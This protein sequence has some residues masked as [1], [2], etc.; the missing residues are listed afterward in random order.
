M[1]LV[2]F[3]LT[4]FF[5]LV[6]AIVFYSKQTKAIQAQADA[7][8]VLTSYVRPSE[9][10]SD[11][12]KQ[13]EDAAKSGGSSVAGHMQSQL[14]ELTRFVA[15][16]PTP[17][18]TQIQAD[19]RKYGLKE[20]DS[21]RARLVEATRVLAEHES[22]AQRLKTQLK[23]W[24]QEN[25]QIRGQMETLRQDH[26]KHIAQLE[27]Q[28]SGYSDSV[29]EYRR[30]VDQV[31]NSMLQRV[32][33]MEQEFEEERRRLQGQL[34]Q[35]HEERVILIGRIDE[36]QAK[37]RQS[38]IAPP[39]PSLLVDGRVIESA[40]AADQIFIDR[41][42]DHRI[43]LGMRFEVYDDPAALQ[44]IDPATGNLPRGKASVEVIKVNKSTST[45]K[46]IRTAPGRPVV[47]DDVIANAVYDPNYRFKFMVHGKFDVDGDGRPT[48]GEADYLRSM[49]VD[50][51]GQVVTGDNLPGDLDFL[52]LGVE[53]PEPTPLPEN[54]GPPQVEI[55]LKSRQAQEGYRGLLRQARDAQIPVLN[56]NRFFILTGY[57]V[58]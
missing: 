32:D 57:T 9:R 23:D 40:G 42:R 19:F 39:D 41:G 51:G 35:L 52:I 20:G 10:N 5:L 50:W 37:V 46:V 58:R 54:A 45:C 30:E 31:K 47:R 44:Q 55:Y 53:P 16:E 36:L 26:G 11:A 43:V 28:I 48:E 17:S 1:A 24:E 6:L 2:V 22:E 21:V 3:I 15:G 29:V 49:V 14:Q 38:Q 8:K 18:M 13:I 12:F 7:E 33:R 27:S 34:D 25:A 4:T 56:H